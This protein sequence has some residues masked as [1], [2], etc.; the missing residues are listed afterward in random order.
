MTIDSHLI[1]A[2]NQLL[3]RAS[4]PHA[5]EFARVRGGANN[6]VF[7]IRSADSTLLLKRY[8][9]HSDDQRN[10][11]QAEFSFGQFAWQRGLRQ[12]PQPI[13]ADAPNGLA[14]YEFIDGRKIDSAELN[15]RYVAAAAEFVSQLNQHR[16]HPDAADLSNASEACF[17]IAEHIECLETR[18]AQLEQISTNSPEEQALSEFVSGSLRLAFESIASTIPRRIGNSVGDR[19]P[20]TERVLSPSDFGFH[21]ALVTDDEE[22][23][24]FDF[25]Y[26][27]WD[28]PAKLVCDFFC[29]IEVPVSH[30]Y[31]KDFVDSLAG[32]ANSEELY[33]RVEMLLPVYRLKWCCILL[34][35]FLPTSSARRQFSGGAS[36]LGGQRMEQLEK[37]RAMFQ[38]IDIPD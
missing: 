28:D 5:S 9:Q 21:N 14:L 24:F 36:D 7:R 22:I 19:L 16:N 4:L 3:Q 25:E 8:F 34:N 35:E 26:A 17:S 27:G 31:L 10:R 2:I 11:L 23:K 37:A 20:D 29:Q 15:D 38:Q 13:A 1:A 12:L 30:R 18:I 33:R 6:R 32:L